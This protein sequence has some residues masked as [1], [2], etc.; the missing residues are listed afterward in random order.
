MRVAVLGY[1]HESNTFVDALTEVDR[2]EETAW[3]HGNEIA[4]VE[5][6]AHSSMAGFLAVGTE[7]GVEVVPLVWIRAT[8]SGT[9]AASAFE[10]IAGELVGALE[11]GGP[12]DAVLLVLHGAAVSERH[13]DAD[14]EVAAR[15]RVA[16]GPGVPIGLA[17]DMHTNLSRRMVECVTA[18]TIYRTNPHVDARERALECAEI[19]VRT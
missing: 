3:L 6:D 14:G 16:V 18:T 15:V 13:R 19:I 10:R 12:W 7:P 11:Q 1:Y 5:G 2:F 8:P 4:R 9:I 17:L